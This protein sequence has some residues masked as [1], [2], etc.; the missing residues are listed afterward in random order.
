MQPVVLEAPYVP[1]LPHRGRL[2]PALLSLY[3]PRLLRKSYG[4][5]KVECR[6][7]ER[8]RA[9]L[10]A[11]HGVVLAPNHCRDE[12]PLVLGALSKAAG[13]P[14]FTIASWHVFKLN[15]L[16]AFLLPRAG[17][18]SIYR[19][20]T[21]R[22]AINTAV[23]ILEN[24]ERPLVIFP[25]GH[26]SRTNDRLGT[27]MEG[28][29]L[30]ARTAAKKRA[31]LPVPGKV[32]A[33]P[34]AIRYVFQ[35]DAEEAATKVLDEIEA[36]LTWPPRRG[37]PIRD[38]I[39]KIGEALLTL[40]ELEYFDRPQTGDIGLRLQSLINAVLN[41]RE[42]EWAGGKHDGSVNARVKRLRTAI[43]PDLIKGE[44]PESERARR[45]QHLADAYL[46]QQL[47][48]YPP[49]YLSGDVPPHRLIET[50]ERFEEDLTD[51]VRV[52]GE[53]TAT[54]T[55]G[56]PIEVTAAREGRGGDDP[57]L[58]E[59]ERKLREM[60]GLAPAGTETNEPADGNV[61]A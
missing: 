10:A 17:A 45:W 1:V 27:L 60:L 61:S 38:R 59:I 41:P 29:T 6:H 9:S 39:K 13:A 20:G 15:R 57:L 28:V 36:R 4:V 51:K 23:G 19:E 47:F 8:L 55:V 31:K 46:A 33:H 18:F 3:V 11:G 43:L 7:A 40:K 35:G 12:D 50:V 22:G 24:A 25:E 26:I 49:D 32:V 14:F 30:I 48:H 54:I 21:D 34:I 56:E 2:W 58:T 16:N 52:H 5:T 44:L 53:I 42:D 37:A